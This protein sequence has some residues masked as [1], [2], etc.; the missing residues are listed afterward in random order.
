MTITAQQFFDALGRCLPES[1]KVYGLGLFADDECGLD[2]VRIDGVIDLV[3]LAE[4]LNE[5]PE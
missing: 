1:D 4:I 2:D 5:A 3:K